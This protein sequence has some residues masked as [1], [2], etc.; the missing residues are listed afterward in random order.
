MRLGKLAGGKQFAFRF[1]KL[2]KLKQMFLINENADSKRVSFS[3]LEN[4]AWARTA[5]T[6]SINLVSGQKRTVEE[7]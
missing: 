7:F 6:F 5:N 3:M 2:R 4:Q 1:Q